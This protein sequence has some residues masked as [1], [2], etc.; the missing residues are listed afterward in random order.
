MNKKRMTLC[1]IYDDKRMLL[2]E[3]VKESKIKG[4]FNAFGGKVEEGE[5]VEEA[6]RREILEEA[7]II[8]V[9]MKKRGVIEFVMQEDGNP[10]EGNPNVELHIFSAHE[11]EGEL[12]ASKEMVP[13]WFLHS[14]IPFEQMWP[15]DRYWV[16][17]LLA[18]KNF[19]GKFY[20]K[21]PKTII[22]YSLEEMV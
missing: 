8:P 22:E 10:F 2:G 18:G 4:M 12:Q 15:D 13:H 7:G 6:A 9:E 19:K 16:P 5:T 1:C 11:F 20:L 21:D 3:I 17:M 14:E